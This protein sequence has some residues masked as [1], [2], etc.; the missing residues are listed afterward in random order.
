[1]EVAEG[2]WRGHEVQS[3]RLGEV[4]SSRTVSWS[5]RNARGACSL[6]PRLRAQ[7]GGLAMLGHFARAGILFA[8]VLLSAS[9]LFAQSTIYVGPSRTIKTIQGGIDAAVNGDTVRI[10]DATYTGTANRD[11]SFGGEAHTVQAKPANPGNVII[12]LQSSAGHRGFIFH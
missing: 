1:M 5:A 3:K 4:L 9:S 11:I 2:R 8:T 10:D 7:E 6:N 12:D